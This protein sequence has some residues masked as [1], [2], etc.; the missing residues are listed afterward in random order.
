MRI[1]TL[2]LVAAA[3]AAPAFAQTPPTPEQRAARFDAADANK[4]GKLDKAEFAAVLPEQMKANAD[5]IFSMADANADGAATKE[6][7]LAMRR[8]GQ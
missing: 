4:D 2:A 1:A 6:E 3:L 5:M 7:F 8:P